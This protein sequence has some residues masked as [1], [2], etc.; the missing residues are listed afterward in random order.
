MRIGAFGKG[1]LLAFVYCA[2]FIGLVLMQFPSSGPVLLSAGGAS[3][4]AI[5]EPDGT[6]R[7]LDV[8]A[9]GLRLVFSER[10]LLEYRDQANEERSAAVE[11]YE[12]LENGF[13]LRFDDGSSL[14]VRGASGGVTSWTLSTPK[15][16]SAVSLPFVSAKASKLLPPSP[17][18]QLRIE[19]SG[20]PFVISGLNQSST[21]ELALQ[22]SRGAARP[23][24]VS[25]EAKEQQGGDAKFIAQAPMDNQAWQ[26]L[27]SSWQDKAWSY[28]SGE[29]YDAETG[30]WRQA[31]GRY[32]FDEASFIAFASE[33][34]RRGGAERAAGLVAQVRSRYLDKISWRSVPFAG[35]TNAAMTEFEAAGLASTK[36]AERRLL[37][38]SPELFYEPGIIPMLFDRSPY[39]LAQE[40]MSFAG[41]ADF[42]NVSVVHAGRLLQAYVDL[43][44]YLPEDNNPFARILDAAD[45]IVAPAIRRAESGFYILTGSEGQ[46]DTQAG[47]ELGYTLIRLGRATSKTVYIGMG[48]SIIKSIL[49]TAATDGSLPRSFTVRDGVVVPSGLRIPAPELYGI[50]AESAFLPRAISFFKDLGPGAWAWTCAPGFTLSASTELVSYSVDFPA[51]YSHYVVVYGVKPF[52]LIQLYGLNYNMD[53]GFETYNASG[54]FFKRASGALYVKMR[55]RAQ[56]EDIRLIY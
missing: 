26:A 13:V 49:D 38:K 51:G 45:R 39:A 12:Q 8:Q 31:D 3:L 40:A 37:A 14:S 41:S 55:H 50:I 19:S 29:R 1:L 20:R 54:Y 15:P 44:S 36:E 32:A 22:V 5:V 16:I 34:F 7:S 4:R 25:P 28:V 9:A 6:L 30:S 52:Q 33:A 10:E 23:V 47:L 35:R 11:G 48:Q 2:V 53:A 17:E 56:V 43:R 27:I 46:A 24:L 18:G 42:S 21:G